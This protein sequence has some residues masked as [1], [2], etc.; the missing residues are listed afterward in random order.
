MADFTETV[1][2]VWT[3]KPTDTTTAYGVLAAQMSLRGLVGEVVAVIRTMT[4]AE[5]V[6]FGK[7]FPRLREQLRKAG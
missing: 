2:Q 1:R 3:G 5:R 6:A 4:E 7:R